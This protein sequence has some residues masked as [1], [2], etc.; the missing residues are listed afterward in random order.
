LRI[1]TELS[2]C[3]AE[4]GYEAKFHE[5]YYQDMGTK[6]NNEEKMD[7]AFLEAAKM[8]KEVK[9]GVMLAREAVKQ[10]IYNLDKIHCFK[11]EHDIQVKR[12]ELAAMKT[13]CDAELG[14]WDSKVEEK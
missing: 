12:I 13:R 4:Q 3:L 8:M 7:E 6:Y 5:L 10:A 14:N 11:C 1:L 9:T 2:Q